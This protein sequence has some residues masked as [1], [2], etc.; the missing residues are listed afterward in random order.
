ML[1]YLL[2]NHARCY[3][4]STF[5]LMPK[6]WIIMANESFFFLQDILVLIVLHYCFNVHLIVWAVCS[7][8]CSAVEACCR[9]HFSVVLAIS[10]TLAEGF[11]NKELLNLTVKIW[12]SHYMN[13][14]SLELPNV[15]GVFFP[16]VV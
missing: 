12:L 11:C 15:W 8:M 4:V 10:V 5:S 7:F 3:G 2:L 6:T 1:L 9:N 13:L 14:Y 16:F